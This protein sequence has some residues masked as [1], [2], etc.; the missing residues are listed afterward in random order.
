VRAASWAALQLALMPPRR[1]EQQRSAEVLRFVDVTELG[2]GGPFA[3]AFEVGDLAGDEL[4][5]AGG[6]GEFEN[7]LLVRVARPALGLWRRSRKA[8]VSNASPA[9][10]AMPSPKTLWLV[11]LP[12]R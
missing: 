12:R 10:T 7:D 9:R 3:F 6:V 1:T 2:D 8:C 4:E 5:G 11:N